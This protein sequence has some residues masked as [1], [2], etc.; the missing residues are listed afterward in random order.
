MIEIRVGDTTTLGPFYARL[1]DGS[2][3]NLTGAKVWASFATARG[4]TPLFTRKN[5]AG[6][7]DDTQVEV[8]DAAAGVFYVYCTSANT[9]S[10]VVGTTYGMDA[11]VTL[12]DGS[13]YT[14]GEFDGLK[15]VATYTGVPT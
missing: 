13:V 8:T 11:R 12:T 2:A 9:T 6:G 15:A 1:S 3:I 7:G 5:T 10:M 14:V 4:A